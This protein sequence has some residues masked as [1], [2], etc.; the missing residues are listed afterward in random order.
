M[1]TEATKTLL[2]IFS[3]LFPVVYPIGGGALFLAL[4]RDYDG[5]T[6][7]MLSR[8]IALN[9]FALLISSFLV[10]SHVL[11][12]F[13]ISLAIVQVG[14]GLVVISTAWAMLNHKE[15]HDR[16]ALGGAIN[17]SDVLKY[18]FYPL[19]LPLTVGPGS[20][21]IAITLGASRPL[22][23]REGLLTLVAAA[24]ASGLLALSV[25]ICYAFSDRL[26]LRI[27]RNGMNVTVRLTSFLL[28]CI[29]VQILWNGVHE[30]LT[31]M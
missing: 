13:G 23:L 7:R 30:L 3:T 27:G 11:S 18:A 12:F 15:S 22:A 19:T 1:L 16:D 9:S 28:F 24:A 14:G 8:R 6:R 25:Y 29:G 31:G 2:L 5:P 20:I 10:G 4:T 26:A 17:D 21:S